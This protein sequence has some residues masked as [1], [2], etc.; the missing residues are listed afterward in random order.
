VLVVRDPAQLEAVKATLFEAKPCRTWAKLN[1]ESVREAD[2][3]SA[4]RPSDVHIFSMG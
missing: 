3:P 4:R 1:R 2:D